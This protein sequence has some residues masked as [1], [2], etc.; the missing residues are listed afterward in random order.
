MQLNQTTE[1]LS[2]RMNQLTNDA[3]AHEL[4]L[5]AAEN[6]IKVVV[7]MLAR[8]RAYLK[9]LLIFQAE[10]RLLEN[11]NDYISMLCQVYK[12]RPEEPPNMAVDTTPQW[13]IAD[14]VVSDTNDK[15][16]LAFTDIFIFTY[17]NHP[18]VY[19]SDA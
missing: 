15:D 2:Y 13:L 6:N 9:R 1:Q 17:G 19:F 8:R 14:A 4:R 18:S 7:D 12:V 11:V 10:Q 3:I 16:R 5:G